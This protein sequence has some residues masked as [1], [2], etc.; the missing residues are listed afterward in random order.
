M[1]KKQ[2]YLISRIGVIVDL[3]L[4]ELSFITAY[5][6]RNN[7]PNFSPLFP[8]SYY[9]WLSLLIIL[10]WG[11]LLYLF[12]TYDLLKIRVL[13]NLFLAILKVVV[14]GIAAV[15]I[16]LFLFHEQTISRPLILGF[17]VLNFVFLSLERLLLNYLLK[18][19]AFKGK[20]S[21]SKVLIIGIGEKVKQITKIIE[22]NKYLGI[23]I[24]D[25]LNFDPSYERKGNNKTK[26]LQSTLELCEILKNNVID[27]VIF[28]LPLK[29]WN[30]LPELLR[31]CEEVGVSSYIIPD[32]NYSNRLSRVKIEDFFGISMLKFLTIPEFGGSIFFKEIFDWIGAC[33]LLTI[34]SPLFLIIAFVIKITSSGPVFF[35]QERS[36]LYG[37]KFTFY[38]F[39]SMVKN[40]EEI[41]ENLQ[42]LNETSGPVFKIKN[43]PR[44]TKFGRFLRR[45]T[46]DELPQLI[47]VIKGEMS[48]VG[49]RPP[50][51]SEVEKYDTWQRRRLSMKPGMTCIWQISG[52]SEIPFEKWME[53]DLKYIDNWSLWLD[54][55]ILLK[56]IPAILSR[57]GA[58]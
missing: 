31:S 49:P 28:A 47:N 29:L 1:L 13:R 42:H 34:L 26:T 53:L 21:V 7:I 17:G 36:G 20:D 9:N 55:K 43:D 57:K 24:F 11:I 3:T 40:A 5:F 25:C 39:R 52:R 16:I 12:N 23:E 35:K 58:W 32:F 37:R 6:I 56:T 14:V 54:F 41:K 22:D 18:R 4:T 44:V 10:I 45:T 15:I 46:L 27:Y 33:L 8:L 19:N 2:K 30:Y 51:P 38:K 48:L 50:I